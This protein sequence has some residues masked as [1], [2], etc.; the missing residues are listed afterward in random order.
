METQKPGFR[1][2]GARLFCLRLLTYFAAL[3]SNVEPG[4]DRRANDEERI[5]SCFFQP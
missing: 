4:K 5:E 1:N 3:E 2:L